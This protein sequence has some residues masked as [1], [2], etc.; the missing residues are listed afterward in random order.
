MTSMTPGHQVA[1]T[2]NSMFAATAMN[3]TQPAFN[4]RT[5][6]GNFNQTYTTALGGGTIYNNAT[7]AGP[8]SPAPVQ[9]MANLI[10]VYDGR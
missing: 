2:R 1:P 10:P 5:A 9:I 7:P 6:P 8:A 3:M 4:G